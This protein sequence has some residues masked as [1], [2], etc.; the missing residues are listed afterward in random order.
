MTT[1]KI[2]AKGRLVIPRREREA[3]GLEPGDT[4]F[5]VR[6][7]TALHVARAQNP[8]VASPDDVIPRPRGTFR[9]A[10]ERAA[11]RHRAALDELARR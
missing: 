8:F 2:D 11:V 7:G 4:V 1:A 10:A 3:L 5:L 6:E 9:E